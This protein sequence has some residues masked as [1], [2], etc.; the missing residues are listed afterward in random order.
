M[1]CLWTFGVDTNR[2]LILLWLPTVM[3][4]FG[5]MYLIG[6]SYGMLVKKTIVA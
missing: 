6:V 3:L 4:G 1:Q 5:M 2:L